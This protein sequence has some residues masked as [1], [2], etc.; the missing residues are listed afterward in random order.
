MAQTANISFR[1]NTRAPLILIDG[2]VNGD[3]AV[4]FV[5]DTGASTT[6]ISSE[7]ATRARVTIKKRRAKAIGADG[8][9]SAKIATLTSLSVGK[10]RV[11]N[12]GAAVMD[13]GSLNHA[14]RLNIGGILGFNFLKRYTTTINYAQRTIRFVPLVRP[15]RAVQ[16]RQS[17]S[18][19]R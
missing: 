16:Q 14:T 5:V 9:Q 12:L 4:R 18:I 17:R 10:I 7:V 2:V 1:I 11:A 6:V 13:L 3:T 15:R 19:S 8:S